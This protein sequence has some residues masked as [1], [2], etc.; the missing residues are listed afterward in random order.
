[1][2]KNYCLGRV[3]DFFS[4]RAAENNKRLGVGGVEGSGVA[5]AKLSSTVQKKENKV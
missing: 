2:Q 1:L 3:V 4:K 5:D